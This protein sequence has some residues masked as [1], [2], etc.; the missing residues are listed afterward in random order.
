MTSE[1]SEK[2]SAEIPQPR[3]LTAPEPESAP[4]AAFTCPSGHIWPLTLQV[5]GCPGC[6]GPTLAIEA[7]LCPVCNEPFANAQVR[8]DIT[9]TL[10]G[11]PA[12]CQ[13]Q[14]GRALTA[15]VNIPYSAWNDWQVLNYANPIAT[16]I[17]GGKLYDS[18]K[19]EPLPQTPDPK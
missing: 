5:A 13:G 18:F 2:I 17:N 1:N 12:I 3:A 19:K 15:I 16:P 14:A 6:Q 11:I 4:C 8:L 7:Q 9:T 10:I